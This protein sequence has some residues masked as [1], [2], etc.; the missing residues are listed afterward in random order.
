MTVPAHIS[1]VVLF[2]LCDKSGVMLQ[3]LE[4]DPQTV[5]KSGAQRVSTRPDAIVFAWVLDLPTEIDSADAARAVLDAT[6]HRVHLLNAHQRSVIAE[7]AKLLRKEESGWNSPP[8]KK[9]ESPFARHRRGKGFFG[10]ESRKISSD[11]M[12]KFVCISG[13]R[14]RQEDPASK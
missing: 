2:P 6:R 3:A 10:R 9:G 8:A 5:T 11:R 14:D 7:L 13:G 4:P 1:N 12:Q